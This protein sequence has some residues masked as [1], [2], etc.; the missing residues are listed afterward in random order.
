[1]L[2]VPPSA[3][4]P[5]I[6][7]GVTPSG[8]DRH[9]RYLSN[10]IG[11]GE[12]IRGAACFPAAERPGRE[13]F[14]PWAGRDDAAPGAAIPRSAPRPASQAARRR[15]RPWRAAGHRPRRLQL[16]R[17]PALVDADNNALR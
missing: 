9:E 2:L 7:Q 13:P 5:A 3:R 6:S 15:R 4:L 8:G 16:L 11:I 1:P 12:V 14:R 10:R 17:R